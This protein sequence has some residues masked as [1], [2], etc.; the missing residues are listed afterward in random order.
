MVEC[1]EC[2][3]Q[4]SVPEDVMANEIVACETCGL[5]LEVVSTS[6]VKVELAPE[7]EEDWGE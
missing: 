6:P 4:V 7:E 2:A 5:E 3:S 1:P